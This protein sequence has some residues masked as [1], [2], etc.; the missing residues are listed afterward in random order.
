MLCAAV[1]RISKQSTSSATFNQR[2]SR[3]RND[4]TDTKWLV[5]IDANDILQSLCI[6]LFP[7]ISYIIMAVILRSPGRIHLW[8][9]TA[10]LVHSEMDQIVDSYPLTKFTDDLQAFH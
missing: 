6:Q 10:I 4:V 5:S 7:A 9:Y 2:T 8:S 3:P 1:S